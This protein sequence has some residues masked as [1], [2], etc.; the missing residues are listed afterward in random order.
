MNLTKIERTLEKM[1]RHLEAMAKRGD[2]VVEIFNTVNR[3]YAG[4][5][6]ILFIEYD[7]G[8]NVYYNEKNESDDLF[9][10][11]ERAEIS[12]KE[13]YSTTK[14]VYIPVEITES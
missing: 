12:I 5:E 4:I 11:L 1:E 3:A 8:F 9:D 14:I 13:I 10:L 7:N 6:G 2:S